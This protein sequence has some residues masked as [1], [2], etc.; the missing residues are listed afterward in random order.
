[1]K[2]IKLYFAIIL[3]FVVNLFDANAQLDKTAYYNFGT[4]FFVEYNVLPSENA[5]SNIINVL[6]KIQYNSLTFIL[7]N[8][9]ETFGKYEAIADLE[10]ILK[11]KDGITRKKSLVKDTVISNSFEETTSKIFFYSNFVSY[12]VAKGDYKLNVEYSRPPKNPKYTSDINAKLDFY[13]N[14]TTFSEP[15]LISRKQ[16]ESSK[17]L[18]PYL[19]N[20]K[21]SFSSVDTGILIPVNYSEGE[22]F[23]YEITSVENK[24]NTSNFANNNKKIDLRGTAKLRKNSQLNLL[25]LKSNLNDKNLE[26]FKNNPN[27]NP[28]LNSMYFNNIYFDIETIE[29]E[30]SD[31]ENN[32]NKIGLLDI[33]FPAINTEIGNYI[34]KVISENKKDTLN[35]EFEVNWENQPLTLKNISYAI[36]LMYYILS[37]SQFAEMDSG[38]EESKITKFVD[39]WK[40]KD[41]TPN[42]P[43]NE[44][45]YQY[46]SRVDYAFFNFQTISQSDGAKT[47]KGKIYILYG[48]PDL[49]ENGFNDNRNEEIWT[50]NK[51]KKKYYFSTVSTGLLK[52]SKIEDL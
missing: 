2:N 31:T 30:N 43:F 5:D 4:P 27:F 1:M 11:D 42:T 45:M 10:I 34:L 37:D 46:F 18:L 19:M 3:I 39:Y 49:M 6:Y 20:K 15:I 25:K 22:L 38:D 32:S 28:S 21:I 9:K 17:F 16:K 13:S 29:N 50:Y 24:K 51:F 52:L 23:Y 47:D 41:P 44:A 33:E 7:S 14:K 26:Q 8:R 12:K 48:K 40:I 36:E 35:F